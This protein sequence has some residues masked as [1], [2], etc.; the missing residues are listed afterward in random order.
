MI[1][2][3]GSEQIIEKPELSK[4]K[5]HND[6]G[7]GFYCTQI[8]ELAKEWACGK[9]NDGFV[10]EY[11]LD[12]RGLSVLDLNGEEYNILNWLAVLADNRSYWQKNSIAA[13]AKKYISEHFSVDVGSY[14]IIKGY[15]ADDSYFSF[16]RDFV[17]GTI[18]LRKLTEAMRLGELGEQIVLKS[19]AAFEKIK[20]VRSI[21][22]D[23]DEYYKKKVERDRKARQEYRLK[24]E[25][26]DSMDDVFMLDIIREGMV[27]GDSRLR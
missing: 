16:A 7:R 26:S 20:F 2:Y 25:G 6:Y 19:P 5:L 3:H 15:R 22:A 18:S 11:T 14:D 4:G 23:A 24:K 27:N 12:I 13:E 17:S 21:R 1:L 8:E 9:N 10:N